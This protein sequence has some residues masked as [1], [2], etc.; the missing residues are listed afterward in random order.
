[1]IVEML[2]AWQKN[3]ASSQRVPSFIARQLYHITTS[4]FPTT[5]DGVERPSYGQN[6]RHCRNHGDRWRC[7]WV[8]QGVY[9]VSRRRTYYPLQEE[10]WQQD[11]SRSRLQ[12]SFAQ[13]SS[14]PRPRFEDALRVGGLWKRPSCNTNYLWSNSVYWEDTGR[15]VDGLT[16][17]GL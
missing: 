17:I 7:F 10:F 5:L 2:L 15:E 14:H 4:P 16:W 13:K 11:F 3:R 12:F 6:R 8:N 1:M 9:Q